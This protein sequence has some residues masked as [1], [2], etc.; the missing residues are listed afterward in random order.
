MGVKDLAI[1]AKESL[2]LKNVRSNRGSVSVLIFTLFILTLITLLILADI[3][4][5]YL[6]KRSLTQVTEGAAQ[7]GARNLDSKEYYKNAYTLKKLASN[8][9]S[10]GDQDP[11]I[12]I[13][14]AKASHDAVSTLNDWNLLNNS[15]ARRN[16]K[17]V[18]ITD[19]SCDGFQIAI[20]TSAVATLPI[21]LP[22]T[23]IS[24]V[25][26]TSHVG[27]FDERKIP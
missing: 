6:A 14:C 5:I 7:R 11:G 18:S 22:F 8:I 13:D 24:E 19:I 10:G 25:H 12:P 16:I 23:G 20:L 26:I 21:V 9:L 2:S 4:S 1:T 3:S 27:I 15:V 17:D